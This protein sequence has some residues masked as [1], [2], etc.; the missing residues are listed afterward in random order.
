MNDYSVLE[1]WCRALFAFVFPM[2]CR[3]CQCVWL[4]LLSATLAQGTLGDGLSGKDLRGLHAGALG[5]GTGKDVF[6]LWFS[7]LRRMLFGSGKLTCLKCLIQ[8]PSWASGDLGKD[9]F[10]LLACTLP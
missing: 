1:C 4:P 3:I 10:F 7:L 9:V 5:Q 6:S 2:L 8:L